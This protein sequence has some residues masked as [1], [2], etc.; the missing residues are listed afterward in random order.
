MMNREKIK[1]N[2]LKLIDALKARGQ[3]GPF[4]L[5]INILY[6]LSD[7]HRSLVVPRYIEKI[8]YHSKLGEYDLIVSM[9][10]EFQRP[11]NEVLK[12]VMNMGLT[13]PMYTIEEFVQR[14][15]RGINESKESCK[16]TGYKFMKVYINDKWEAKGFERV[17]H[18]IIPE[19]LSSLVS[20]F[21]YDRRIGDID[22]LIIPD[23]LYR[24]DEGNCDENISC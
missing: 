7:L 13:V 17:V 15:F 19:E 22:Y 9:D 10:K 20:K 1:I 11:V 21:I 12:A 5:H 24:K 18:E 4:Y 14:I 3:K 8:I 23:E 16:G 6:G 2:T